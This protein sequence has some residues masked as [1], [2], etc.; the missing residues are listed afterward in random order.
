MERA[1]LSTR[2]PNITSSQDGTR[3]EQ[4]DESGGGGGPE[5]ELSFYTMQEKRRSA[6]FCFFVWSSST[7]AL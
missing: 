1:F 3:M 5:L 4:T 6:E 7:L 2:P